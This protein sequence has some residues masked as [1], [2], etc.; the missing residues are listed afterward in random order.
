MGSLVNYSSCDNHSFMTFPTSQECGFRSSYS[1]KMNL[2]AAMDKTAVIPG[3]RDQVG[4]ARIHF[5]EA[6]DIVSHSCLTDRLKKI[7]TVCTINQ[8]IYVIRVGTVRN[9]ITINKNCCLR[10]KCMI[11]CLLIRN[12][13]VR[14]LMVQC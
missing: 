3:R 5:S 1:W 14:P 7:S 10:S 12:V 4:V 13:S 8:L 2:L 9:G 6:L 11:Y